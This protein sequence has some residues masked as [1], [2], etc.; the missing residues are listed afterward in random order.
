MAINMHEKLIAKNWMP[1][2]EQQKFVDK[3]TTVW[4]G[5]WAGWKGGWG[6]TDVIAPKTCL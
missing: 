2:F 5:R 3:N 4:A 6:A 1:K